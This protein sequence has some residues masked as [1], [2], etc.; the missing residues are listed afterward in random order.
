LRCAVVGLGRIGST[1]EDD[2]LREKPASHAGAISVRRDCVLAA[3]CDLREDRRLAFSRRWGCPHV[4]AELGALLEAEEP[5][6]LHIATPT[7]THRQLVAQAAARSVPVVV[8]EKPLCPD[9]E[10]ARAAVADCRDGGTTL[11]VNHERRYSR[12]YARARGLVRRGRFGPLLSVHSRVYMGRGRSPA[13]ILL[14]DG[15][16]MVDAIR[17][18]TGEDVQPRYALHGPANR[19]S[20]QQLLFRCGTALGFLEVSGD[21]EALVF[22]L[23]LGFERGRIRIG[24]GVYEEWESAPSRYYEGFHSL[25][26]VR[27]PRFRRTGYFSGMMAD[28]VAVARQPGRIPV[29]SGQD[30]LRAVET[31]ESLLASGP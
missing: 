5:D 12:D 6:I 2:R 4:Y 9:A 1:L 27:V 11:M 22:E 3:G 31:I 13:D 23:E 21:H 20:A 24:N 30:G 18:L 28:A 17:F 14:E 25:R 26:P 29:S 10:S 7:E 19:L 8:C 16:H 15:T